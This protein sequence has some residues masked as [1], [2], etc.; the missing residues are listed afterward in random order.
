MNVE[1]ISNW[2]T[3]YRDLA[4]TQANNKSLKQLCCAIILSAIEDADI[5]FLT[6]DYDEWK[7]YRTKRLRKSDCLTELDFK[8]EFQSKQDY[9][10]ILFDVCGIVAR[11]SDIPSEIFEERKM[12]EKNKMKDLIKLTNYKKETLMNIAKL[13]GW[14]IGVDYVEPTIFDF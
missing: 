9:K 5:E 1:T 13:H 4:T 10:A 2:I 12:Y 14:K 11:S 8:L 7:K 3:P 6:D